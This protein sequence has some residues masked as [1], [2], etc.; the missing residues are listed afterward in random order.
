MESC[1]KGEEKMG[2]EEILAKLNEG[3]PLQLG[4]KKDWL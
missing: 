4:L 2:K 3:F 1:K